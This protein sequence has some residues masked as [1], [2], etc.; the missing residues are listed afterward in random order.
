MGGWVGGWVDCLAPVTKE[1]ERKE[2]THPPTHPPPPG[3]GR[4]PFQRRCRPSHREDSCYWFTSRSHG[5]QEPRVGTSFSHPPTHPPLAHSSSFKPPRSP[6]SPHNHS[7][8]H[9]P[10]HPPTHPPQVGSSVDHLCLHN[11]ITTLDH[12]DKEELTKLQQL[13]TE[14]G[15]HPSPTHPP[16]HPPNPHIQ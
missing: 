14:L 7:P 9:P 1:K 10:T 4:R 2:N 5:R 8:I 6:L 3:P 15:T 13:K 12:P 16:T 11:M